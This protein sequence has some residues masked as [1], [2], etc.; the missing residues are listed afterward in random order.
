MM[1]QNT[2][3]ILSVAF[4]I[5]VV[6]AAVPRETL[7]RIFSGLAQGL[8]ADKLHPFIHSMHVAVFVLAITSLI[9]AWVTLLRPRGATR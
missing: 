2:G 3:A 4:V 5:A 7:F 9:G 6:T 1:F 8:D